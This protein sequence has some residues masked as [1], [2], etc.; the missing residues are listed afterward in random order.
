MNFDWILSPF[1]L[2][3]LCAVCLGGSLLLWVM[4]KR[5]LHVERCRSRESRER[6]QA[7]LL[8]LA[9]RIDAIGQSSQPDQPAPHPPTSEVEINHALRHEALEMSRRNEPLAAIAAALN[10][11]GNEVELLLRIDRLLEALNLVPDAS[12]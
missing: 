6:I 1:T 7:T 12:H 5:E 10:L 4:F 9:A 11:P 8:E 2:Y 3:L